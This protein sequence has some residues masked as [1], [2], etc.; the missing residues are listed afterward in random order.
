MTPSF[1]YQVQQ[2]QKHHHH[3][4]YNANVTSGHH[5]E[6]DFS[7]LS[8]PA[9]M[10][11]MDR[12]NTTTN[13]PSRTS[14]QEQLH[15]A[16]TTNPTSTSTH[17]AVTDPTQAARGGYSYKNMSANQIAEQYEQLEHAKLLINQ[18][19]SELQKSQRS[20]SSSSATTNYHDDTVGYQRSLL[21][22][23]TT[24]SG[25][26]KDSNRHNGKLI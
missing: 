19:L 25:I 10:P 23:S 14:F 20:N 9:I 26:T 3:T 17:L 16:T 13:R 15:S 5:N 2:Q 4:M 18:K 22:E 12:P 8:S 11:Q 7:P 1:S 21:S 6:I 24:S